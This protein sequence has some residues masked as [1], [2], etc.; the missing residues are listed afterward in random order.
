MTNADVQRDS[1]GIST[2]AIIDAALAA[3]DPRPGCSW[4]DIGC[5][6]GDALRRIR[7][8]HAPASLVGIDVV[9]FLDDDLR[10]DVDFRVGPA[11][12]LLPVDPVDRVLAVEVLEH[13]EAPWTLLRLAAR[14]VAPGGRLVTST[15]NLRTIK[16]RVGLAATGELV[17][18]RPSHMPH[19]SPILPHTTQRILEEEGLVV[20]D[21]FYSSSDWIPKAGRMWPESLRARFPKLLSVAVGHVARRPG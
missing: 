6:V 14:C 7:D 11:E 21:E 20:E 5:G 18:F 4:L 9:D 13:V 15:P 17:A 16:H 8:R 1:Y 2:D 3:A 12:E 10:G 19:L